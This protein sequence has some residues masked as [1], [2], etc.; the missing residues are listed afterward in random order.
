M[1]TLRRGEPAKRMA[2]FYATGV[3][4]TCAGVLGRRDDNL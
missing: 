3:K 4:R 2:K 1:V